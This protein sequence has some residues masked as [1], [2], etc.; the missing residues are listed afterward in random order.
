[1]TSLAAQNAVLLD[2]LNTKQTLMGGSTSLMTISGIASVNT[3]SVSN[4]GTSEVDLM[5][6]TLPASAFS[7]AGKAIRVRG[8]GTLPNGGT[9]KFKFGST[10]VQSVVTTGSNGTFS[11]DAIVISKGSNTQEADCVYL[12]STPNVAIGHATPAET[13]S[14]S[15]VV[16]FTATCAGGSN[17]ITQTGMIVEFF[18]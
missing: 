13:E 12:D 7:A 16:K 2:H 9:L 1:M 18:N 8:W 17:S 4:T 5:T 11:V 6:Y 10:T 14:G 15:I 3:S